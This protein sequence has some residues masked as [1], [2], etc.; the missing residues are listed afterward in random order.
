MHNIHH[1]EAYYSNPTHFDAFRF[2]R[3]REAYEAEIESTKTRAATTTVELGDETKSVLDVDRSSSSEGTYQEKHKRLLGLK[4]QS[5]FTV[6]DTF[7]A[8]GHSRHACPG[9]FLASRL[10]KL[11]LAHVIQHYD[12]EYMAERPP[13]RII[14]EA[15]LPSDSATI[16][17]RRRTK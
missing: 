8:F 3:P 11:M 6:G 10:M 15:K 4:Q 2:S 7:L 5:S 1:D 13:S 17:V 14:L 12:V 16:R 9:R